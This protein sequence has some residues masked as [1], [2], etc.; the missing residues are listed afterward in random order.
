MREGNYKPIPWPAKWKVGQGHSFGPMSIERLTEIVRQ[1]EIKVRQYDPCDA[2]WL[3]IVVDFM[4]SAQEQEIRI[5]GLTI[6]SDVFQ[7]VIIYKP[8]FEHIVEIAPQPAN[9]R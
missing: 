7:K 2:Y 5:G 9:V 4:D 1:K 6:D 8:Y 3:L